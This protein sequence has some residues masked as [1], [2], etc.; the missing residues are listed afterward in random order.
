MTVVSGDGVIACVGEPLVCFSSPPGS[1]MLD[2]PCA[3]VG[4]GGAEFNVAIHLARLGLPVRF[5]GAI[6]DDVLGRRIEERLRREGVDGSALHREPGGRTGAYVKDWTLTGRNVVYLRA[7]SAASRMDPPPEAFRGVG[8]VH[9]SGITAALSDRCAGLL[10]RLLGRPRAYTVSFDVN[11]RDKLWPPAQAARRLAGM[12]RAA[13]LVLVGLDEAEQLWGTVT[14]AEVRHFL[15]DTAE[16]VVKDDLRDA[17][18]WSGTDR[19]MLAPS[20]VHIT[21]PVG[22]GDAFAAG[23]LYARLHGGAPLRALATGHRLAREALQAADDL[24]R[25]VPS[26]ELDRLLEG[27]R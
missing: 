9:L 26:D 18:A 24:G 3:E 11:Y 6:G 7:G 14:A 5:V 27:D 4:E 21:E 15:R 1:S 17:T 10:D 13:D 16:V 2:S 19:V 8:H 12:A 22:A 25:P 20:P 23:Y